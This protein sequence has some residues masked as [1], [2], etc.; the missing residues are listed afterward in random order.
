MHVVCRAIELDPA[1]L[2]VRRKAGLCHRS[3][4]DY[5]ACITAFSR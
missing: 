2:D 1:D 3:R 4:G 5:P